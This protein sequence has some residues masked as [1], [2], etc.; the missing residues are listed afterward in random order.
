MRDLAVVG[1]CLL[2]EHTSLKAFWFLAK[3]WRR[4]MAKRKLIQEQRTVSTEDIATWF[5]YK[6]VSRPAPKAPKKAFELQ[7]RARAAKSS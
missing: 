1:C 6:P 3:N 5:S 2:W 4:V 7:P